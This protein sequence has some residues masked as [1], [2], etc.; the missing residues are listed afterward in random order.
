MKVRWEVDETGVAHA[1]DVNADYGFPICGTTKLTY[2]D[3]KQRVVCMY[4]REARS[5]A[6]RGERMEER[7]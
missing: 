3:R 7:R 6:E 1:Y 4:C 5:M 2:T